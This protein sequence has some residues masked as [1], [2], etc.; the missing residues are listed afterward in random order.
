MSDNAQDAVFRPPSF[1]DILGGSD[2]IVRTLTLDIAAPYAAVRVLENLGVPMVEA[3]ALAALFPLASTL[4][5][6]FRRRRIEIVGLIV[7]VTMASGVSIAL[8]TSDV[9]F[10]VLKAAP[11]YGLF[12][13]ACLFS[14]PAR[15][16]V[17]FHVARYFSALGNAAAAARFDAL[18]AQPDFVRAMRFLTLVWGIAACAECVLGSAAAF[19]LPPRMALVVEPTLGFGAVA[20]LLT[21]TG[22][23]AR[24]QQ[25]RI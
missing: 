21:W 14:L 22:A 2:G 17:M 23:F 8:A 25:R 20:A 4:L 13:L 3:F 1:I 24:R 19:L 10:S 15:R 6:W 12:G 5:D 11:A 9:R 16:P 7:L 18:V